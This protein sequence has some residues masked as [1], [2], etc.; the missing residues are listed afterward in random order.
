[1][2]GQHKEKAPSDNSASDDDS[3][4]AFPDFSTEQL[5]HMRRNSRRVSFRDSDEAPSLKSK[6]TAST[7]NSSS[8]R[9]SSSES[10]R[11][12]IWS[13]M[14]QRGY[15]ATRKDA[16]EEEEALLDQDYLNER[17]RCS[18][19]QEELKFFFAGL[20]FELHHRLKTAWEHPRIIFYSLLVFTVLTA[21]ALVTINVIATNMQQRIETD[22]SLE[23][24]QTAS[25]FADMF[26]KSLIP[27]RSLQQAVIHSDVFKDL[28]YQIGNYGETGSAPVLPD[29]PDRRDVT[30]IC[31]NPEILQE[32]QSI[33][34][35]ITQSFDFDD[36][37]INYR[38]APYG[39]FCY[40]DPMSVDLGGS[41]FQ[42]SN[43]I[44]WDPMHSEKLMW[45]NMLSSIYHNQNKIELFGPLEMGPFGKSE[46]EIFCGHLAVNMDGY[47][48]INNYDG[49]EKSLWGFVMHFINWG[50]LKKKSGIDEFYRSKEHSFEMSRTDYVLDEASGESFYKDVTIARSEDWPKGHRLHSTNLEPFDDS[51]SVK[52]TVETMDSGDWTMRVKTHKNVH[53]DLFY[54][55]VLSVIATFLISC[56]VSMNLMERKLNKKLLYKIMPPDAIKKLHRGQTVVEK[57][58]IVT[59]FF[60]DIVGFTSMCGEMRP[61]QVMKMLNELYNQFDKLVEKH[62]VYKVETIGDA[63][64]VVGGAPNRLPAPEAAERVALF[65]LEAMD[66][67]KNFRTTDGD[68][69]IIRAGIAS[70][71]AVAG[72]VGTSM[73]RYCFFGDTVNL[74]SRMESNSLKL[75]IQCSD[76][77]YRLLRDAPNYE[78]HM[79]K[80]EELVHLKGKG[81]TQTWWI[82]NIFGKRSPN[83]IGDIESTSHIVEQDSFV[84]TMALNQQAWDRTGGPDSTLVVATSDSGVMVKRIASILE[85]RL[86]IAMNSTTKTDLSMNETI[87]EEI[88]AYVHDICSMYNNVRFHGFEHA[89]HVTISMNKILDTLL[90]SKSKSEKN[91]KIA[92]NCVLHFILAL[93]CLI[94]DVKHTG[95]TNQMLVDTNHQLA[96]KFKF[97]Q[98]EQNSLEVG[99]KTLAKKKYSNFRKAIYPTIISRDLFVKTISW[100]VLSTD[101]AST[102]PRKSC[103]ERFNELF[104]PDGAEITK[105]SDYLPDTLTLETNEHGIVSAVQEVSPRCRVAMEHLIQVADIA[106]IMQS[107]ENFLKWNFRLYKELMACHEQGLLPNVSNGWYQGQID[108]LL[109]YA[110]P[111]AQRAERV[112]GNRIERL[113]LVR[114]IRSNLA[115]WHIDGERISAMFIS[116]YQSNDLE[117]DI[118]ISCLCSERDYDR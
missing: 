103:I 17:S 80:R 108:F 111:L 88:H 10:G 13:E 24:F 95:K 38:L 45:K 86:A 84:Q 43:D 20:K 98:A 6:H 57:Y 21:L 74:A 67:I 4:Q 109:N 26:A 114:N 23:A 113:E 93:A 32:F 107:F 55:K 94:H 85:Y 28:P 61:L 54:V 65:A 100:T 117:R 48:Y 64:M 110:I 78:F 42:S 50:N 63:Y 47:N 7:K 73:P 15:T 116:G 27:L 77:T 76:F 96:Q 29:Q 46:E 34:D 49:E 106:H 37:I 91:E 75:N 12:N 44:G 71:P 70:G 81:E 90:S 5:V 56:V 16:F 35:G 52:V 53:E 102:D 36:V 118:L 112:C 87:S 69:V 22:A 79:E 33:V 97:S 68:Q 101:I 82:R 41:V 31:D 30:G 72:V 14:T 11:R 25:W 89:S 1:M 83:P 99:L 9:S 60:S 59:I 58:N 51:N 66:F 8:T 40:V 92:D 62:G 2:S 39:V 18:A 3:L 105:T 104:S 115:R 19:R